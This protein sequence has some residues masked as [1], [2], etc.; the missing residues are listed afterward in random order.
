MAGVRVPSLGGAQPRPG[1]AGRREDDP[2]HRDQALLRVVALGRQLA[3]PALVAFVV[4]AP[5]PALAAWPSDPTVNVPVCTEEFDQQFPA[6][7][8]DGAGGIFVVWQDY[9]DGLYY[10]VYAQ[11]LSASGVPQWGTNGI[12]VCTWISDQLVPHIATDGAGGA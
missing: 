5:A 8:P 7:L 11:R 2:M 3:L 4:T 1:S 12:P 9:R 10:K 6:L